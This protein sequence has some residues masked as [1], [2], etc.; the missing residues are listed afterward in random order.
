MML[1]PRKKLKPPVVKMDEYNHICFVH[2]MVGAGV[3]NGQCGI[4]RVA[5]MFEADDAFKKEIWDSSYLANMIVELAKDVN[6][7]ADRETLN[8]VISMQN[9]TMCLKRGAFY[10]FSVAATTI[11][12]KLREILGKHAARIHR[13]LPL[14]INL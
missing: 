12:G 9:A 4:C 7:C 11:H 13:H 2:D 10:D 3:A 14:L 6:K 8:D 1:R 5:D